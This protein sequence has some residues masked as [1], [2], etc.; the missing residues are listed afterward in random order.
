MSEDARAKVFINPTSGS[1]RVRATVDIVDA[2]GNI[3]QTVEN[4]KFCGC[5]FSQEKPYCDGSHKNKEN[6]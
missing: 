6:K 2:D 4:P 3:M 5:G 1:I